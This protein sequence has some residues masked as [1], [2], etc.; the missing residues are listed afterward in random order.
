MGFH[1]TH[2]G[3]KLTQ[4]EDD[5]KLPILLPPAPKCWSHKPV[6]LHLVGRIRLPYKFSSLST[7][8]CWDSRPVAQSLAKQKRIKYKGE[9]MSKW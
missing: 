1:V 6:P 3:L 7:S 2:T 8:T 9:K 5:P 4:A